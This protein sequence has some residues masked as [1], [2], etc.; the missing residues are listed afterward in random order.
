MSLRVIKAGLQTTLQGAPFQ[1]HRHIG[2]PAAGAADCLSLFLANK[3]VGNNPDDVV[4]EISLSG[5]SFVSEAATTIALTGALCDFRINDE[6]R[7]H[8]KSILIAKGDQISIG[9]AKG[10]CRCYLAVSGRFDVDMV[11]GSRSTY[12][13]A[14]LG[15]F[16]GR[17]L[18]DGDILPLR[19]EEGHFSTLSTPEPFVPSMM[20][21]VILRVTA[22]PEFSWLGHIK[23]NGLF[24]AGWT[25]DQRMSRMGLMLNGPK[26]ETSENQ[27]MQS[28]AAFPGT[29]QCPPNGLPFLLGPDAQTTG[30]YP[31]IAHVIKA[32]R[33]LIGQL[34]PGSKLQFV[35]I[36]ADQAATIYREK[37][38]LLKPWLGAVQLW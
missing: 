30:G 22:G 12:Q 14:A 21:S 28:A 11:L 8:H 36:S 29:I 13:P 18:I 2:M 3:L 7:L 34:K 25:V 4:L 31:R 33:H 35:H 19:T 17:S 27:S 6:P 9:P 5:A 26:L 37:L 1:G 20:N 38:K 23:K 10:G 15:G 16:H 32:D 24:Q